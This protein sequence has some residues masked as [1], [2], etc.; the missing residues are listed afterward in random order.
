MPV[1]EGQL[2]EA[3]SGVQGYWLST[4]V[5][6]L[7]FVSEGMRQRDANYTGGAISSNRTD[8]VA[9]RSTCLQLTP[10]PP[11]VLCSRQAATTQ[12]P[13]W[14]LPRQR[15]LYQPATGWLSGA[16][17]SE[18]IQQCRRVVFS[19]LQKIQLLLFHLHSHCFIY[20]TK[21]RSWGQHSRA[22]SPPVKWDVPESW[23]RVQA[24]PFSGN[25]PRLQT[26]ALTASSK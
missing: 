2:Q 19:I 12:W 23:Q 10:A 7:R 9:A 20:R 8:R 11:G 6:R 15:P 21:R 1:S 26:A 25:S 3:A 5:R 16:G 4:S 24:S 14:E 22:T 18:I 13:G 17:L